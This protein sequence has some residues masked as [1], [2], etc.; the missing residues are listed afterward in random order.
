MNSLNVLVLLTD[1]TQA[2]PL[3][4]YSNLNKL[5]MF[6]ESSVLLNGAGLKQF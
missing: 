3:M 2:V 5:F 4:N 6:S 1:P